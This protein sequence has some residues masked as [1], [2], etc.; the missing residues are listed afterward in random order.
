MSN[1][2][3]FCVLRQHPERHGLQRATTVIE[4]LVKELI[5]QWKALLRKIGEHFNLKQRRFDANSSAIFGWQFMNSIKMNESTGEFGVHEFYPSVVSSQ[6][7]DKI[8][9]IRE[10][11]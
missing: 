8:F 1:G 7:R 11:F 3:P 6:V 5:V 4:A 10:I 2:C 9:F